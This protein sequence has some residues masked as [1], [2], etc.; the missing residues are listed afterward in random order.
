[1]GNPNYNSYPVPDGKDPKDYDWRERRA[2]I[3]EAVKKRGTPHGLK[4]VSLA[5]RYDVDPSTITRDFDALSDYLEEHI[6]QE[7]KL[8]TRAMFEK[9]VHELQEEDKWKEAWEVVMDW[10]EY[11]FEIG[12]QEREPERH[13]HEVS[14]SYIEELE[15]ATDADEQLNDDLRV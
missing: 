2:E 12:A 14:R 7:T 1:M 8:T 3:L 13:E 10:N 6:G 5:K 15:A 9:T 4:R 11:L